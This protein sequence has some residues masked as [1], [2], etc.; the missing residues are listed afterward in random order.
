MSNTSTTML[1]AAQKMTFLVPETWKNSPT[2][3]FFKGSSAANEATDFSSANNRG[4]I[5]S[6]S[7][8][9]APTSRLP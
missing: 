3:D 2:P 9:G 1:S 5:K 7:Y 4:A 6:R 8:C